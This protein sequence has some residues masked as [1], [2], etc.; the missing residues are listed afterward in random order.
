VFDIQSKKIPALGRG[1]SI[2]ETMEGRNKKIEEPIMR[3][4]S[5]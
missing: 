2:E 1:V 5:F 4:G 3:E